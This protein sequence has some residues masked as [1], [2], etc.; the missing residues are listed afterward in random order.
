MFHTESYFFITTLN[1][2]FQ[3]DVSLR[4]SCICFVAFFTFLS[5]NSSPFMKHH[6]VLISNTHTGSL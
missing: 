6:S 5:N 1:Q 2:N 4:E 3:D